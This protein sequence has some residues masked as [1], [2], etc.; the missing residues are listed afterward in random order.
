M[1]KKALK[2][3]E[4]CYRVTNLIDIMSGSGED[5]AKKILSDF[6]CP[7]NKDVELFLKDKSID[8]AKRGMKHKNPKRKNCLP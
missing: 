3:V 7:K 5:V 6:S 1:D 8:F 4:K 2:K